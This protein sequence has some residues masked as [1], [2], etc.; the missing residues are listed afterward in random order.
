MCC[1]AGSPALTIG[2]LEAFVQSF[3]EAQAPLPDE[4]S[5]V[6]DARITELQRYLAVAVGD[7]FHNTMAMANA[8]LRELDEVEHSVNGEVTT[9]LKPD[10]DPALHG[11][12]GTSRWASGTGSSA[13]RSVRTTGTT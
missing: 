5:R 9:H 3:R 7:G 13:N 12:P 11:L 8:A 2:E 4:L 6:I 1:L 10:A